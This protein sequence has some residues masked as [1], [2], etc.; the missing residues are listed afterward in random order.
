MARPKYTID[1]NDAAFAWRWID[2]K[3]ANPLWLG[4]TRTY[5]AYQNFNQLKENDLAALNQWCET[6]LG[7][8]EW[9][10]LKNAVRTSRKR[11]RSNEVKN[12]TLSRYAWSVLDFW[13]RRD[14]CTL[15]EVIERRLGGRGGPV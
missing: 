10:Q 2:K 15:S 9:T 12:V 6:W 8:E 3:L 11:S 14:G 7:S 5:A 4:E 13:A 1:R